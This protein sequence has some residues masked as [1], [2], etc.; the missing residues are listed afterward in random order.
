MDAVDIIGIPINALQNKNINT[1][2]Q[3]IIFNIDSQRLWVIVLN[4]LSL[5]PIP[6]HPVASGLHLPQGTHMVTVAT[7]IYQLNNG[8][9]SPQHHQSRHGHPYRYLDETETVLLFLGQLHHLYLRSPPVH[10]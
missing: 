3:W 5:H 9:G 2:N 10:T 6:A 7:S 4:N 8:Y 1:L